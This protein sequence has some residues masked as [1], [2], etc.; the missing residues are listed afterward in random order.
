[1]RTWLFAVLFAAPLACFA[2]AYPARA[3]QVIV[4][5]PAGSA[6]DIVA[7]T[8]TERLSAAWGQG[9]AVENRPGAGGIPGMTALIKSP[10]TGYTLAI[11]PA[12][13]LTLTPFLFKEARFDVDRDI[14]PVA[15]V[16]TTP[17]V[18][19]ARPESGIRSLAELVAA[20]K[21][22]P[23]KVEVAVLAN[24]ATH[25]GLQ[26]FNSVAG[27]RL[28]PVPYNGSPAALAAVLGGHHP[29]LFEG[30]APLLGS[31]RAGKLVPL[32][33]SSASRLPGYESVPTIAETYPGFTVSG[34]LGV[35]APAGTPPG[36]IERINADVDA[37]LKEPQVVARLA[38]LIF[39]PFAGTPAELAE[40]V[41]RERVLWTKIARDA[42][43]QPQ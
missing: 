4:P 30:L 8:L 12:T 39:Y 28:F 42:G 21:K 10:P 20:A 18:L 11:V 13:V 32:A 17:L 26:Y 22:S 40:F 37:V 3:V 33:V 25:Y 7:R 9:V 5:F 34:W 35:F 29:A 38:E 2:Q 23:D 6:P 16:A 14:V 24:G 36:V 27:L 15:P 31:V 41:K 1:M 43:I 19:A